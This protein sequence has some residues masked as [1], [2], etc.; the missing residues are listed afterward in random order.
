MAKALEPLKGYWDKLSLEKRD[1]LATACGTTVGHLR[2]VAYGSRSCS[3]ELALALERET[4]NT[5]DA[6]RA[7]S[8]FPAAD[9]KY[10]RTRRFS[11]TSGSAA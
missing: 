6:L 3:M 2:N 4:R 8:L 7:E 10:L 9:W 5:K 11:L 1:R